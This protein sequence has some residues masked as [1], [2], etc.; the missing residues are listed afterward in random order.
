MR[1]KNILKDVEILNIKNFHNYNISSITHIS[2][3]VEKN[4]MFICINGG[5]FNGDDFAQIA[6]DCGA[7]CVV[8]ESDLDIKNATVIIVENV[9]KSMS[10]IAKNFYNKCSDKL[11]I[12]GVVGT[13][14]K[15]TT[16]MIIANILKQND[17][18]IGVIGTNGI[19]IG[20]TRL[21]NKFT[22][23]DP[24]E[25]HYVFYQMRMFGVKTVVM[26]ISA[27]AIY[28]EKMYGVH[29][30][31]C[32]FTNI[33]PEH[34]DFFGSM[35]NY[36]R[37]KMD[38]FVSNN[39]S[40][41]VVNVD[42]FYGME[43][44][45]KTD[46]P[47]VSYA[48]SSPANSFAIEI[49]YSISGTKFVAN[50]LDE[51]INVNSCLVGD[52]NVYNLLAGMTVAKLLGMNIQDIGQAINS[53]SPID[54]R[55][56]VFESGTKKVLVDFAHTPDSFEKTLSLV[57]KFINGKI[58][59]IFGCVGYSNEE[60]RKEMGR[61][62]ESFSDYLI[63]TTDNI[64]EANFNDVCND[65]K[66]GINKVDCEIIE[67]RES[68][69]RKGIHLINSGDILCVLGKGAEDFQMIGKTRVKYSDLENVKKILKESCETSSI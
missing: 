50:I 15:T 23:P 33:S 18:N 24:L 44:A 7:K 31:I 58:I 41:S 64:G 26:E 60:K 34:L 61:V 62:A 40:E 20:D 25:L 10:L 8:T 36:A 46:T 54:G 35:E 11:K 9:R 22:T 42:D 56:N 6:V 43:I 5:K 29:I 19:F 53:M 39:I 38:Y 69:I 27:Q 59:T 65:I 67:D 45:Y 57:R 49:D 17:K 13:S 14:G 37:C 30:D 12:I 51:V 47:C 2:A 52:F 3:D 63:L 66:K 68:A 16:S 1:L 32:V 48:V 4:G 55:F 21:D 28:F